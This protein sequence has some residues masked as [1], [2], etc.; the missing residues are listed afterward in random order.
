MTAPPS[1]VDAARPPC[2]RCDTPVDQ[3]RASLGVVGAWPC[4]CWLTVGQAGPVAQRLVRAGRIAWGW[5]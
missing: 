1:V 2:P 3:L 5:A 4:G